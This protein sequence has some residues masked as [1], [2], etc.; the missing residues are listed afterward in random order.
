MKAQYTRK[1]FYDSHAYSEVYAKKEASKRQVN[2]LDPLYEVRDSM[3]TG[4]FLL[5]QVGGVNSQYGQI[6]GSKPAGLPKPVE[7]NRNLQTNDILGAEANSKSLG[8]FAHFKRRQVR[9]VLATED[10]FGTQCGTAKKG[11]QTKRCMNPL[12]PSYV[13]P[14]AADKNTTEINDPYNTQACSVAP[15]NFNQ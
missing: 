12:S 15:Q 1:T 4:E 5:G 8:A 3:Q 2:P 11:I 13:L 10:I 6:P 14:G 7:G 9:D